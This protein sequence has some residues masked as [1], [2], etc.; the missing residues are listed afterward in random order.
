MACLSPGVMVEIKCRG[1]TRKYRLSL[2][3]LLLLLIHKHFYDESLKA[4]ASPG[5]S[6]DGIQVGGE[7]RQSISLNGN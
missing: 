2:L 3:L 4:Q 1:S 7:T 5:V 6:A